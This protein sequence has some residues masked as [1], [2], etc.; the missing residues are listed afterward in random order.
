MLSVLGSL[1]LRDLLKERFDNRGAQVQILHVFDLAFGP[2]G[3][4][5]D[6]LRAV[7]TLV[8]GDADWKIDHKRAQQELGLH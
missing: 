3:V 5:L 4:P 7:Y 2:S 1:N 8:K 6:A